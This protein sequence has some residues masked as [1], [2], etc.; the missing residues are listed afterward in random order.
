MITT[1]SK[2]A[3]SRSFLSEQRSNPGEEGRNAVWSHRE[4]VQGLAKDSIGL[5][6]DGSGM[7][8]EVNGEK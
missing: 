3:N 7:K 5:H 2:N 4:S 1:E 6:D 8:K